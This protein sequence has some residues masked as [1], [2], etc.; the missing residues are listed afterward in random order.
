MLSAQSM[1]MLITDLQS[2]GVRVA[3]TI[4][5]RKGGAGPAEGRAFIIGGVAV[6]VPI[7]AAFVADSPY[8]LKQVGGDFIL[9][10]G[11]EEICRL[12]VV[13][14]PDFYHLRTPEH[15]LYKK[16]AVL[17]GSDCLATTVYQKCVYWQSGQACAFCATELS[18]RAGN[19]IARKTPA[20]LAAV[21]AAAT[22]QGAITHVVL[23]SGTGDPPHSEIDYLADCA[24]AIKDASRLPVHV[25]FIPPRDLS[26]MDHLKS[27]GVDT[28]GIHIES[29]DA[30]VLARV[31]PAKA[32]IGMATYEKAWRRAVTVFGANQVSSFLIA[33]LGESPQSLVCGS[34]I[35]ADLGVFPFVVPLRPI[36]RSKMKDCRPPDPQTMARI[37]TG[38]AKVLQRKGLS[39][40]LCKAGCVR[41]GAC[42]ALSAYEKP[43]LELICHSARTDAEVATAFEIRKAVFVCEQGLFD[44]SDLDEADDRSIHLVAEIGGE[45]VGTVRVFPAASGLSG[46]WIGSRLAVRERNRSYRTGALLVREAMKRVKKKGCKHFTAHIQEKNVPFFKKLGWSP[47]GPVQ[48]YLGHPHQHMVADLKRV[49]DDL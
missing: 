42:S 41:C 36:P 19:T 48:A 7:G 46:H 10:K 12:G 14:D 21:A 30:D 4:T 9:L 26:L 33:G 29:F 25:Q 23:T 17:H 43:P 44:T 49:P 13:A 6:M 8:C 3:G 34:E 22:E 45:I 39:S 5:G 15:V 35:L 24:R 38:V 11:D 40:Q 18:L 32:A 37:Y 47:A 2:K 20:Q 28:V 16:I 1:R 31:A 27:A